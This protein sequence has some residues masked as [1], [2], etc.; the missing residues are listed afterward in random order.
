MLQKNFGEYKVELSSQWEKNRIKYPI[1]NKIA[2][3]IF[4]STNE[5]KIPKQIQY[6][7]IVSCTY[8]ARDIKYNFYKKKCLQKDMIIL[9]C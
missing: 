2:N 6:K 1:E 7:N 3:N 9:P 8:K 5:N 4:E